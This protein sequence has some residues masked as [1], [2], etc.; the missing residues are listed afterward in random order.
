MNTTFHNVLLV[1]SLVQ[2]PFGS[3]SV[4]GIT[5]QTFSSSQLLHSS[6]ISASLKSVLIY[7]STLL[8][9]ILVGT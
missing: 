6:S 7:I 3:F 2:L 1:Y 9:I 8:I 4:T 5:F